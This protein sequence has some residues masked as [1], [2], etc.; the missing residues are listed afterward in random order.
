MGM[1]GKK[2]PKVYGPGRTKQS[3][4]EQSDIN[5]IIL[6]FKKTG[7]LENASVRQGVFADVSQLGDYHSVVHRVRL[8]EEAFETLP[9]GVRK[10]F[11]NDPGQLLSFL[12][13]PENRSEAVKLGLIEAPKEPS[14]P[15]E[16]A[17]A[18]G[19]PA[20]VVPPK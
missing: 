16:P 3:F 7:V 2:E 9:S 8:A 14:K 18:P 20:P 15:V 10:K 5:R 11:N 13:D 1:Y 4:A 6:R 19:S 12:G 17:S